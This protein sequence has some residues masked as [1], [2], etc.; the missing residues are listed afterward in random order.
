MK[1][2]HVIWIGFCVV[3]VATVIATSYY[4]RKVPEATR[5]ELHSHEWSGRAAYSS[6]FLLNRTTGQVWIYE[7]S[8]FN[9]KVNLMVVY[10]RFVEVS[11]LTPEIDDIVVGAMIRQTEST[12]LLDAVKK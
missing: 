1:T 8:Y 12:N 2:G 11:R 5:W 4:F 10:K 7:G 9:S 6:L 3:V